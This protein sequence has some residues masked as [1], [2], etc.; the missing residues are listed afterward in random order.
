[1]TDSIEADR[2]GIVCLLS[3]CGLHSGFQVCFQVCDIS[4]VDWCETTLLHSEYR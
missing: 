3:K 1:V 4:A 2:C